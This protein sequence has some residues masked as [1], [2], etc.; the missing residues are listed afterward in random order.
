[1]LTFLSGFAACYLGAWSLALAS[2]WGRRG[3]PPCW[4]CIGCDLLTAL[5]W[6]MAFWLLDQEDD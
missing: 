6:P 3:V 1:M 5:L 4:H 2:V